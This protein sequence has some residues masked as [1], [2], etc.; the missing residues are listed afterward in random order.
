MFVV[1]LLLLVV[2]QPSFAD[3]GD[4]I[5]VGDSCLQMANGDFEGTYLWVYR[6]DRFQLPMHGYGECVSSYHYL[7]H[8]TIQESSQN[9]TLALRGN[10]MNSQI[11]FEDSTL[12]S[13]IYMQGVIDNGSILLTGQRGPFQVHVT[14]KL[15][16][17][18]QQS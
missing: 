12:Q 17:R 7:M 5:L 10:C 14:L 6:G 16:L 9:S 2:V 1:I 3:I 8:A 13:P 15:Q 11:Y 4:C 18:K